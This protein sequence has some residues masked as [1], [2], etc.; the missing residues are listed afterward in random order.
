MSIENIKQLM[1]DFDLSSLLP[2]LENLEGLS[3][4]LTR[5]A[6]LIGPLVIL[7]LGLHYFLAAP[8]EANY[9]TGY[10]CYF[11]MGSLEAWRF[12]Q[13]LAG[14]VWGILGLLMSIIM[15]ILAGS[16]EKM[17]LMDAM[18]RAGKYI[19][20]EVV[21]VLISALGINITVAA[22]FDSQGN[23]RVSWRE[24]LNKK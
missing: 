18:F 8:K 23:R 2:N 22:R 6:V 19:F 14:I 11:G 21:I 13:R 10:R 20:W 5:L 17:E 4:T 3:M 1:D 24:L 12:T 15:A 9:T 7:G 16:L